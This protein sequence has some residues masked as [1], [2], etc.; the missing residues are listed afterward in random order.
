MIR[1]CM[2]L[3]RRS[4][5]EFAVP[6]AICSNQAIIHC[7]AGLATQVPTVPDLMCSTGSDATVIVALAKEES[8]GRN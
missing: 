4:L 7:V 1:E 2:A 6:Q 5:P 8:F 3:V